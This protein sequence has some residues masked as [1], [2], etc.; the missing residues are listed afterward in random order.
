[1]DIRKQIVG[2]KSLSA[3]AAFQ[4]FILLPGT[5]LMPRFFQFFVLDEK[6]HF[7]NIHSVQLIYIAFFFFLSSS[8][9]YM[10]GIP[11][12]LTLFICTTHSDLDVHHF[13]GLSQ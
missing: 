7:I 11:T 13:G 5:S 8:I 2:W 4:K 12:R 3:T 9:I 6:L 1:M 10:I